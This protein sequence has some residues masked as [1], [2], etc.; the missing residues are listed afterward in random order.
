MANNTRT[1]HQAFPL[2][3]ANL[4]EDAQ[5]VLD[6]LNDEDR[7][8][9]LAKLT[10]IHEASVKIE[11]ERTRN[12]ENATAE[13]RT[14]ERSYNAAVHAETEDDERAQAVSRIEDQ[15]NT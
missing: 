5:R 10:A 7:A 8:A 3:P 1:P 15:L 4:R 2:F 11:K 9:L 14:L 12:F 13:L 6:Q